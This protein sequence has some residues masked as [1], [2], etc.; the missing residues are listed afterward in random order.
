VSFGQEA[1]R[2][3]LDDWRTAPVS[4]EVRAT[5]GFLRALTLTPEA[6]TA[7][8]VEPLRSLGLGDEAIRHA[9]YVCAL[10]NGID[11]VAD[12]L[13]FA[14]PSPRAFAVGARFLLRVGYR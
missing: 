1:T 11:R 12:A 9:V 14:V 5:L 13:D 10:F 6:V 8:D 3:V 2:A 7:A 4:E